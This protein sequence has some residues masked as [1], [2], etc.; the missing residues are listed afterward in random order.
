MKL[1]RNGLAS[2]RT[3]S[4]EEVVGTRD[5]LRVPGREIRWED[6]LAAD[7]DSETGV[8]TVSLVEPEVLTYELVDPA[9]LLQ[10]VRERVTASVVLS[11]RV[12][13]ADGGGFT[14][15]ARRAPGGGEVAF[16]CE[17]D[18]EVDPDAPDVV[19]SARAAVRAARDDL[20]L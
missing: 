11:R 8:L 2:A 13:L 12:P 7:W 10:L 16:T 17:Y 9:L 18:R 4:G 19:E 5:V 3:T 20:G 15:M 1:R 6:I 14:L